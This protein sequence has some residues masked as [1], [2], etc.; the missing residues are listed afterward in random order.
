MEVQSTESEAKHLQSDHY[1]QFLAA[2]KKQ[3]LEWKS[4]WEAKRAKVQSVAPVVAV[5]LNMNDSGKAVRDRCQ[6]DLVTPLHQQ[7]AT[8]TEGCQE[9]HQKLENIEVDNARIIRNQENFLRVSFCK[10]FCSWLTQILTSIKCDFRIPMEFS[11]LLT[12][13]KWTD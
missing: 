12:P 6:D 10:F 7:L 4:D 13:N 11:N 9:L 2:Q 5:P 8:K 3:S 1:E